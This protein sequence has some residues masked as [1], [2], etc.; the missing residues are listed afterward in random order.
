[1]LEE[2]FAAMNINPLAHIT[3]HQQGLREI[4]QVNV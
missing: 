1:M 2:Q 3:K 4:I